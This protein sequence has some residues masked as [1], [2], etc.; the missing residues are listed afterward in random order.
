[1]GQ[2]KLA[3]IVRSHRLTLFGHIAH[4]GDNADVK[5]ILSTLPPENWRRPRGAPPS[6][7]WASYSRIWDPIISHWLKQWMWP[8]T[9]L[10]GGCGQRTALHN[11][12]LHARNDDDDDGNHR[13][14]WSHRSSIPV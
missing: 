5:R 3:A 1:M 6:H 7:A 2:P 14:G 10:C 13:S 12:E 4:V 9:G 8:R 11:L